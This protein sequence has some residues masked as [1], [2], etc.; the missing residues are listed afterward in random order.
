MN[1]ELDKLMQDPA[2]L[3]PTNPNHGRVK[4]TAM[5][6]FEAQAAAQVDEATPDSVGAAFGYY[7]ARVLLDTP[8]RRQVYALMRNPA[9]FDERSPE[10]LLVK[11]KVARFFAG[12]EIDG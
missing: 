4:A 10:H 7:Q 5:R 12:E 1:Q 2:Y 11:R 6:H 8:E 9:Y 3:D